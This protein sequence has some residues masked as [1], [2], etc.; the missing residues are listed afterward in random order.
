MSPLLPKKW[1]IQVFFIILDDR[2]FNEEGKD[3]SIEFVDRECET[4]QRSSI[5]ITPSVD[6]D[7]GI[8]KK[9]NQEPWPEQARDCT[10]CEWIQHDKK[11][12]LSKKKKKML[13]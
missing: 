8:R 3:C 1:K 13:T 9:R 12:V 6:V 10:K 7:E 5:K 4:V 11:K 2:K